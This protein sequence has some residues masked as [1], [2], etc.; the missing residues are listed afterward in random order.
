MLFANST[1]AQDRNGLLLEQLIK[2]LEETFYIFLVI[3]FILARQEN[4]VP[5]NNQNKIQK[6]RQLLSDKYS[7][8]EHDFIGEIPLADFYK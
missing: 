2:S 1:T 8:R 3:Y 4:I 6:E 7:I 5:D